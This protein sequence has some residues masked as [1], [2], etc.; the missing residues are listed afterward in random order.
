[1]DNVEDAEEA[2][3]EAEAEYKDEYSDFMSQ[4]R[5]RTL[6]TFKL[7]ANFYQ[8][9]FP[10]TFLVASEQ[11]NCL[12]GKASEQLPGIFRPVLA[13]NYQSCMGDVEEVVEKEALPEVDAE[14]ED[15]YTDFKSQFRALVLSTVRQ[16]YCSCCVM[17]FPALGIIYRTLPTNVNIPYKHDPED[18]FANL[19]HEHLVKFQFAKTL[20]PYNLSL[21]NAFVRDM[22]YMSFYIYLAEITSPTFRAFF[23]GF[24]VLNENIA[25]KKFETAQTEGK[26][27]EMFRDVTVITSLSFL[28]AI[29]TPETPFWLTLKGDPEKAEKI[30]TWIRAGY[31]DVDEFNQMLNTVEDYS[32][33]KRILKRILS[34]TFIVGF[35]FSILVIL[36]D[37]NPCIL[38]E[39]VLHDYYFKSAKETQEEVDEVAKII[40]EIMSHEMFPTTLRE[41]GLVARS[42]FNVLFLYADRFGEK[43]RINF[44]LRW[45]SRSLV[46]AQFF[47]SLIGIPLLLTFMPETKDT[48]I[49]EL[50]QVIS[51]LPGE[52]FTSVDGENAVG[53]SE[54]N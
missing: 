25:L 53:E 33:D 40:D 46:Y 10:V 1:M 3:A 43:A 34:R 2:L 7:L 29:F 32:G 36:C 16:L 17:I 31:S 44:T 51:D 22:S 14:Y 27:N 42:I 52:D 47:I 15:E 28:L 35:I 26:V 45:I 6:S 41:I 18:V 20:Y 39:I 12:P 50:D 9:L 8:E 37:I 11:T 5:T 54:Q 23:M 48:N 13:Q 24:Y 21:A 38:M 30:F 19:D 4:L 49:Y